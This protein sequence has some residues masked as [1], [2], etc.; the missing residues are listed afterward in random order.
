MA[1]AIV[2]AAGTPYLRCV[3]IA[4]CA[5]WS[6]NACWA[7]VSCTGAAGGDGWCLL[8][9]GADGADEPADRRCAVTGAPG[10]AAEPGAGAWPAAASSE[11]PAACAEKPAADS[12]GIA[13]SCGP[14]WCRPW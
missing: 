12:P 3:A 4:P 10:M 1:W 13:T 14:A 2:T 5:T 8:Y 7:F 6:M 11:A 9:E